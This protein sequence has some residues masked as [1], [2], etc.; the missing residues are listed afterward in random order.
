M[1]I[2]SCVQLTLMLLMITLLFT[3]FS[4]RLYASVVHPRPVLEHL[5]EPTQPINRGPDPATERHIEAKVEEFELFIQPIEPSCQVFEPD[6]SRPSI[7]P[8]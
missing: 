1:K 6:L 4:F 2:N 5:T 3:C 7:H 8:R